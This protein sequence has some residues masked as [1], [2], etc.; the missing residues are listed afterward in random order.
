MKQINKI[1]LGLSLLSVTGISLAEPVSDLRNCAKVESDL[2][3][4][5]CF[6]EAVKGLSGQITITTTNSVTIPSEGS[7]TVTPLAVTTVPSAV[8]AQ[9]SKDT[10]GL[11][12]K[13]T[14]QE[15]DEIQS[16]IEGEFTGWTG[17]TVFKLQNGQV[18]KQV[19][20]SRK[21]VFKATNPKVSIRKAVFGSYRLK[22]E[23]L[24][25]TVTV[26]RVK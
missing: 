18:W 14:N 24:N 15:P 6:D 25:S 10:F 21:V 26:R 13:I 9:P 3:R 23:G 2:K 22:V 8:S 4:L 20:P 17:K 12:N 11:G 5:G 7:N 1:F 19:D 16:M